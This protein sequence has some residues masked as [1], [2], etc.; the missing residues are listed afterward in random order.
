MKK[1][2]SL[3][4]ITLL[5]TGCSSKDDEL[6]SI[7]DEDN[8]IIVDVRTNEEYSE[9][10]L[11]GALNIPYDSIDENVDLDTDKTI[12]VYCRSGQRSKIA[13]ATLLN[14]G[15]DVYDMGAFEKIDLPKE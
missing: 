15:F 3:L 7:L 2:L 5:L 8:Y 14:L 13:K 12:L 1:F 11:V 10:H 9:G 4:G 6:L